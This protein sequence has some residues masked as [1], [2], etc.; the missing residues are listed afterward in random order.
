MDTIKEEPEQ[1][2]GKLCQTEGKLCQTEQTKQ[3]RIVDIPI[4][5][6]SSA[7]YVLTN[8]I[9]LAQK[10]GVFT[11]EESAKIFECYKQF[12]QSS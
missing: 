10:R 12:N 7:F 8:F 6:Q 11:I 1:T 5:D 2:E 3:V 9:N 4:T